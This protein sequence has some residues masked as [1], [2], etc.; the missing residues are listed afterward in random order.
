V[1]IAIIE[2]EGADSEL[3]ESLLERYSRT[4]STRIEIFRFTSGEDFF[5][6]WPDDFDIAFVDIHLN[7]LNGIQIVSRIRETDERM[8]IVIVTNNPQYALSGYTVDALDYLVKPVTPE[9]LG[10]VL[11]RAIRRLC[12]AGVTCINVRNNDGYFVINLL[13]VCYIELSNRRI[14]IHTDSEQIPCTRTLQSMEEQL[15]QTFFRC[16][17]AFIVNLRKVECLKGQY[18]WVCG[19]GIPISKHRRKA[20]V[21]ALTGFVG[22]RL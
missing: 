14:F 10:K 7:G 6:G 3:L 11:R 16:H 1:K 18:V 20:F 4:A 22:E 2:D 15:P 19:K 5:A 12:S 17:S 9:L 13:D 8:V 21:S